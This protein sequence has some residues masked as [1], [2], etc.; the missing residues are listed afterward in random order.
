M[1]QEK[2]N[3]KKRVARL[4][5]MI[6]GTM[7]FFILLPTVLCCVLFVKVHGLQVRLDQIVQTREQ[8]AEAAA[9]GYNGGMDEALANEFTD[10]HELKEG[11]VAASQVIPDSEVYDGPRVYLTFDDGPSSNTDAILDVLAA[12]N[13]KATFFVVMQTDDKSIARYNRIIEEGHTLGMHSAS[14]V[15]SQVYASMDS[16]VSDVT[17]LR[18]YLLS[19]T[20]IK[21]TIYRFPGG[22]SN[23]VS[24]VPIPDCIEYLDEQGIT[25]FDWNVASG[26]ADRVTVSAST[27]TSN[28]IKGITGKDMSVVLLHD[29]AAKKNTVDAL[30]AILTYCEENGYNV[31]P[32]TD[33]TEGLHHRISQ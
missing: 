17:T 7:A 6:L 22:S 8:M 10:D 9:A 28:V 18:D 21:P 19:V 1:A 12:H 20:G 30:D 29:A 13:V 11:Q 32:I 3:R 16:Y 33:G 24:D 31:L 2:I 15:Y 26:D 25:Y 14:H 5:K 4:K 23:T 27:I